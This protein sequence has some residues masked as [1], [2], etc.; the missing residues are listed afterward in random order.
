MEKNK[1]KW[2]S[3]VGASPLALSMIVSGVA[4]VGTLTMQKAQLNASK[5]SRKAL[6]SN[7]LKTANQDAIDQTA[8]LL[9]NSMIIPQGSVPIKFKLNDLVKKSNKGKGAHSTWKLSQNKYEVTFS[10]CMTGEL[11][12]K[13]AKKAFGKKPN[14]SFINR[15]FCDNLIITKVTGL[16][17]VD[18]TTQTGTDKYLL[19]EAKSYEKQN[20]GNKLTK[21]AR[22]KVG[23]ATSQCNMS[24]EGDCSVDHCRFMKPLRDSQNAI[25]YYDSGSRKGLPKLQPNPD[26]TETLVDVMLPKPHEKLNVSKNFGGELDS[27]LNKPG[28]RRFLE[29]IY[30]KGNPRI[31]GDPFDYNGQGV[32]GK[33]TTGAARIKMK[34][35]GKFDLRAGV[36][37]VTS[38][39]ILINP[40]SMGS[41][42]TKQGQNL[43][44]EKTSNSMQRACQRTLGTSADFCQRVRVPYE[45]KQFTYGAQFRAQYKG[46]PPR[47]YMSLSER[48][49]YL[50]RHKSFQPS[51]QPV[52]TLLELTYDKLKSYNA[53]IEKKI[54]SHWWEDKRQPWKNPNK[55]WHINR[56]GYSVQSEF[57]HHDAP[58]GELVRYKITKKIPMGL[59]QFSC[60]KEI[61]VEEENEDGDIV[62]VKQTETSTCSRE[63]FGVQVE[64]RAYKFWVEEDYKS[65]ENMNLY[66]QRE[67]QSSYDLDFCIYV[68]Y[69]DIYNRLNCKREASRRLCRNNNGCFL[70]G[71]PILMSNGKRKNIENI[72]EGDYVYNPSTG[73]ASKVQS[74]IVGEQKK[75]MYNIFYQ[76]K[77]LKATWN[78]PFVTQRGL[79]QS[80]DLKAGDKFIDIDH[81]WITIDKIEKLALN[82]DNV[83]WNLL[84]ESNGGHSTKDHLFVA[85]GIMTGDYFLQNDTK[86]RLKASFIEFSKFLDQNK[87]K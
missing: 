84:L 13:Q 2:Q 9:G 34:P 26:Y 31:N 81:Q 14:T 76:E 38:D 33:L 71:T 62:E 8:Q 85:N 56:E 32:Q 87:S 66:Q 43:D 36:N 17:N 18:L 10:S 77:N 86:D 11:S 37:G 41:K 52:V 39:G 5:T 72:K 64:R 21:R 20:T 78:H 6:T 69:R 3:Q 28:Y 35:N 7:F 23:Q 83:V 19:V 45:S 61:I 27:D 49:S 74:V 25:I 57:L 65:F 30:A 55:Y 75:P 50:E 80:A 53:G 82:Q 22:L 70:T 68:E 12:K 58:V 42:L 73:Q 1:I 40:S 51:G 29:E 24:I 15:N 60:D 79:L 54:G 44:L 46:N 59:E 47:D 16:E 67:Y 63:K 4:V 48:S